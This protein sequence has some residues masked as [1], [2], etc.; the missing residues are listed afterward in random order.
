M[1]HSQRFL[2]SSE[3]SIFVNDAKHVIIQEKL[4]K[5]YERNLLSNNCSFKTLPS[6]FRTKIFFRRFFYRTFYFPTYLKKEFGRLCK[7]KSKP[8]LLL[9]CLNCLR[10]NKSS[11]HRKIPKSNTEINTSPVKHTTG[12][13]NFKCENEAMS[14][15]EPMNVTKEETSLN[16]KREATK[17]EEFSRNEAKISFRSS[18]ITTDEGDTI[19]TKAKT[20]ENQL[21]IA[22][23]VDSPTDRVIFERSTTT[24][25]KKVKKIFKN[26]FP[27]LPVK[28]STS[29][30]ISRLTT[31]A[32]SRLNLAATT[33]STT[34]TKPRSNVAVN[35][36]PITSLESV[37]QSSEESRLSETL[38]TESSCHRMAESCRSSSD[39]NTISAAATCDSQSVRKMRANMSESS[40]SDVFCYGD[41]PQKDEDRISV[42]SLGFRETANEETEYENFR[43]SR[44]EPRLESELP[45]LVQS[46]WEFPERTKVNWSQFLP[47]QSFRVFAFHD[48]KERRSQKTIAPQ[49]SSV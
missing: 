17:Y 18:I 38:E 45:H 43:I 39:H 31:H 25:T 40:N 29:I 24:S 28:R 41:H 6:Y 27:K 48:G 37:D 4:V 42:K 14:K 32:K 20:I 36:T 8:L 21:Q 7:M 11:Y 22:V 33:V 30:I 44:L 34:A 47:N 15:N 46:M 12:K 49:E 13:A 2:G 35:I 16:Q 26:V 19:S 5:Y 3:S 1:I 10:K 9:S 23:K